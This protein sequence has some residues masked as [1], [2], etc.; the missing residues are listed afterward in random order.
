MK[1]HETLP[2][3]QTFHLV[4][5]IGHLYPTSHLEEPTKTRPARPPRFLA[6]Q[7]F[8]EGDDSFSMDQSTTRRFVA[9]SGACATVAQL[10]SDFSRSS[11]LPPKPIVRRSLAGCGASLI[12]SLIS[13][14]K[15]ACQLRQFAIS[16]IPP[17]RQ[18][19]SET[20]HAR[21]HY[22]PRQ[23]SHHPPLP[24]APIQG[25]R[26]AVIVVNADHVRP[27]DLIALILPEV[28]RID[29]L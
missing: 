6:P 3:R 1:R 16:T 25:Q 8:V 13:A 15:T 21:R 24:Q 28:Q 12:P 11:G 7:S 27:H 20:F 29:E 5:Q 10:C 23:S 4:S 14:S 26:R 17:L 22:R 2:A 18:S 19:P 9:D